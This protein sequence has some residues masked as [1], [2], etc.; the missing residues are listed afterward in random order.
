MNMKQII[1]K[2]TLIRRNPEQ[3]FSTI[4]GEVVML[5]VPNEEYYNLN[6]MGSHIWK[7]LEVP[8]TLGALV[9]NLCEEFK[10]E[11]QLCLEETKVF[12]EG[13]MEKNIV[14]LGNG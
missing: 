14:Q 6:I 4:D 11:E 9:T 3:L 8:M 12:I 13:L 2:G 10:V 7:K 5:S 1:N